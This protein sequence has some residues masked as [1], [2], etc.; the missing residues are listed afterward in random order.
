MGLCVSLHPGT[1]S[2]APCAPQGLCGVLLGAVVLSEASADGGGDG[3][4]LGGQGPLS[5]KAAGSLTLE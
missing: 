5:P 2:L 3:G 1:G 4:P